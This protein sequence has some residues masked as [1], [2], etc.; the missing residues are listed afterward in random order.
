MCTRLYTLLT[1]RGT[2]TAMAHIS[3]G[4]ESEKEM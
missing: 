1:C 2:Y 4:Q 3:S